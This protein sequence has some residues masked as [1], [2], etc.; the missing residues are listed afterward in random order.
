MK[1]PTRAVSAAPALRRFA[2]RG[3]VL[4]L[5]VFVLACWS[6][7]ASQDGLI[8][9]PMRATEA[10]TAGAIA[11]PGTTVHVLVSVRERF[12]PGVAERHVVAGAGHNNISA[13]PHYAALLAGTP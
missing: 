4:A 12:R 2:L 6:I 9:H 10:N 8:Y 7:Y 1:N 5:G 3:L 13:D 11:L